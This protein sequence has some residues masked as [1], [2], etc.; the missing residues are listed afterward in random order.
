MQREYESPYEKLR[1]EFDVL[2][3]MNNGIMTETPAY[4][5]AVLYQEV[6]H[7]L[8]KDGADL[9][10]VEEADHGIRVLELG[11]DG[12]SAHA[13]VIGIDDPD[14][15]AELDVAILDDRSFGRGA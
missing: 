1:Q 9:V 2:M 7:V 4:T 3:G 15:L 11:E 12:E 6:D 10:D 5:T 13:A 8:R 14:H